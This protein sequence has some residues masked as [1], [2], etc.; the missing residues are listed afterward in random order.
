LIHL[1]FVMSLKINHLRV[2]A[3]VQGFRYCC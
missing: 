3:F 2:S 1:R